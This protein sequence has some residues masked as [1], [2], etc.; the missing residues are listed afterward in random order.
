MNRKQNRYFKLNP[1]NRNRHWVLYLLSAAMLFGLTACSNQIHQAAEIG[2]AKKVEAILK[3]DPEAVNRKDSYGM[4]PLHWAVDKGH[5]RVAEIL[6]ANGADVNAKDSN[7]ETP[8]RYAIINEHSSVAT[9]LILKGAEVS[10]SEEQVKDMLKSIAPLHRVARDGD[11]E[12]LKSL[13]KKYPDQVNGRDE[14]GRTPLYW[15]ARA[16]HIEVCKVLLA[17]KADIN[18]ANPDG[19]TPLHTSVYNRKPESVELLIA[20]GVD[21]NVQN[22]DGE[23]PL[24][25]AARRGKKNLIEPLL[26]AG[27]DVKIKDNNGKTPV[28]WADDEDTAALL[29]NPVRTGSL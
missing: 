3:E 4:T 1:A 17:N 14:I 2:N 12:K 29:R 8:L 28:D 20:N 9:M 22:N 11:A 5:R 19:W 26:A 21:V 7:G 6:I 13:I 24:H 18:A 25:W 27:A 15:A 16:E 23:T 10:G